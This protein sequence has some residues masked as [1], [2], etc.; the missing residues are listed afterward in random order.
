MDEPGICDFNGDGNINIADVISLL[1]FMRDNPGD[2]SADF[3]DDGSANIADAIAMLLA[4]R[5]GT[6]PD[7]GVLLATAGETVRIEGLTA[8]EISYLEEIMA[9]LDLTE[10]QEAA[11]RLALYGKSGPANLPKMYSL[12]QN[13]PNPF[14]PSTT[15]SYSVPEGVSVQV[16]LKVYDIRGRQ[17]ST[18]VNEVREPG[19]YTVF[20]DGTDEAGRQ[21]A[22]GVYF[23][24][25]QAGDF[26]QT[27]KMVL[28]K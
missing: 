19:T 11:F 1:I 16:S 26:V 27:R 25:M 14:N 5:D 4:M 6:C 22:S 13:V 23:Y 15:I 8:E 10:E 20:W 17:V 21:V 9:D 24:R 2:L 28:L 12:A 3:N 7:A 18:L